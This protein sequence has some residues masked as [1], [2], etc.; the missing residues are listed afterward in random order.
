MLPQ[1]ES[2]HAER[3]LKSIKTLFEFSCNMVRSL[4]LIEGRYWWKMYQSPSI[5]LNVGVVVSL[6]I[7]TSFCSALYMLYLK[8]LVL[9]NHHSKE[10]CIHKRIVKASSKCGESQF[11]KLCLM[12]LYSSL[13]QFCMI[14][15]HEESKLY[16]TACSVAQIISRSCELLQNLDSCKFVIIVIQSA[17]WI[18]DHHRQLSSSGKIAPAAFQQQPKRLS[19]KQILSSFFSSTLSIITNARPHPFIKEWNWIR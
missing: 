1:N 13:Q 14:I 4:S 3:K 19:S 2:I 15:C 16:S 18:S 11:S 7:I 10:S 6:F 17:I 9:L 5:V 8:M 12:L